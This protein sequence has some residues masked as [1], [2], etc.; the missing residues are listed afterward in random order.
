MT[1]HIA[2]YPGATITAIANPITGTMIRLTPPYRINPDLT[3]DGAV[4][5]YR[6]FERRVGAYCDTAWSL[7]RIDPAE[8]VTVPGW[9]RY[10]PRDQA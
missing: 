1:E 10:D 2:I 8:I 3:Q 6:D 9:V 7:G 5:E 4:R